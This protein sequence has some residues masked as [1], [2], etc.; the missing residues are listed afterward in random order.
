MLLYL[1]L[2]VV[3]NVSEY[4]LTA[5]VVLTHPSNI[6]IEVIPHFITIVIQANLI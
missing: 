5:K 1:F 4:L 2:D 3:P 6:W